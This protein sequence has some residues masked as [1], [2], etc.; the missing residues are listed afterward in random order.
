MIRI[1]RGF[2]SKRVSD[3]HS[4]PRYRLISGNDCLFS[5]ATSRFHSGVFTGPLSVRI[6]DHELGCDRYRLMMDGHRFRM[7]RSRL[8]LINQGQPYSVSIDGHRNVRSFAAYF[9]E[10][11]V[12]EV[13]SELCEP[14]LSKLMDGRE[15]DPPDLYPGYY[16]LRGRILR[17]FNEL[18]RLIHDNDPEALELDH[19]TRSLLA[20]LM[21]G[22]CRLADASSRIEAS[23]PATRMELSRRVKRAR[24]FLDSE[25]TRNIEISEVARHAHLSPFHLQRTFK[26]LEGLTMQAYVRNR[27]MQRARELLQCTRMSIEEVSAMVGYAHQSSF[28]RAWVR[29]FRHPPRLL[30]SRSA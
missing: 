28:T 14:S 13:S 1:I 30:R 16:P 10:A 15:E 29:C 17:G 2:D 27:R 21:A 12:S 6:V 7:E 22:Q 8:V 25:Y 5:G 20:E 19:Q 4:H 26:K 11:M 18:Q 23:R 24:N 3:P 9:S